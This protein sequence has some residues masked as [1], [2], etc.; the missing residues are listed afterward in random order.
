MKVSSPKLLAVAWSVGQ[1]GLSTFLLVHIVVSWA[2]EGLLREGWGQFFW[3]RR[4][5]VPLIFMAYGKHCFVT[6]TLS[7]VDPFLRRSYNK[8]LFIHT[9]V[10][11]SYARVH[12]YVRVLFLKS[13]ILLWV[14]DVLFVCYLHVITYIL[15]KKE[16]NGIF[17][18]TYRGVSY[19]SFPDS[20]YY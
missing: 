7:Y 12:S 13:S 2:S 9:H 3:G 1:I 17:G 19:R 14:F 11:Y 18:S 20:P 4:G 5:E 6:K 16:N 8:K 10:F 15:C